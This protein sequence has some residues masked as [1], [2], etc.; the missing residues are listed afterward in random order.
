M[1][2]YELTTVYEMAKSYYPKLWNIN[3]LD[4]LLKAG[5][6]TQEEYDSI[7]KTSTTKE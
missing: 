5:K 4:A 3:R 1:K 7:V 2:V 6:L